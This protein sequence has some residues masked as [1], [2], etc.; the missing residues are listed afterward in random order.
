MKARARFILVLLLLWCL[1][2]LGY[3]KQ[4]SIKKN[5]S[6]G[7][8]YILQAIRIDVPPKIDGFL[9]AE[10]WELAPTATNFIQ[11]Q[12]AEGKPATENTEVRILYDNEN[13]YIGVMCHDS[14]PE[15]IIANEK[16]RDSRNIYDNDHFQIMLDTFHDRRNGYIF[17]INA[18]GAKLDLQV[19]KEGKAEGG[20]HIA[21]PNININWDGVWKVSSA[22]HQKGWSAE[23]EIP[24]VTLRFN[25]RTT[26]GWGVNFL[27]NIRRK[28][29]E[30]SWVPLPRNLNLYKI[31]IAGELKGLEGLKKGLNLQVKTFITV[32]NIGQRG[33]GGK[34]SSVNA[35]DGGVDLKYGLTSNLTLDITV[36]TDFSQVEVDDQQINLTRFSLYFPE[37]RDFFLENA[38]ILSIGSPDD[39]MIFF[40]RRIGI[41]PQREE[42]P[43]LGG[44]KIAGKVNRFNIGFI[45]VQARAKGEIPN[46]NFTVLRVSRD[47]LGK[48]AIGFMMTNRQSKINGDFNRA[49]VIDGDFIFGKNFSLS[50]YFALT[51]S[52]ELKGQNRAAKLGFQWRSDLWDAYGYYFDIQ[53]NFNAEMGFVKRTGIRRAQTHIG[54]TPEP[55]IPGVRRLNPHIF[56]AYTTDQDNNLLLREKHVHMVFD[57]INGGNIGLQWNEDHEYMNYPFSIQ[58]E[59]TVPVGRYTS[60]WWMANF[61]SDRSRKIYTSMSYRWGGFYGGKSRIITLRTGLRPIPS[62]ASEISFVYN[63]I[64]LPQGDFANH[65]LRAKLTYNFSTRLTLMS[66]LQW[67]SDTGEVNVNI[68]LNFIHRPGSDLFI[69]YNE[70]RLVEGLETGILDRTIAVKFTYLFNF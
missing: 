3:E 25:E 12:P 58:E 8:G 42:T 55:D 50:G 39:V 59:I 38:A 56:F 31:S 47:I 26:E 5:K 15:K 20:G 27:R 30:S 28:N 69:V 32:D 61:S 70:R 67:N 46:N 24:L 2:L 33:E 10:I 63:D 16:R 37:K 40:S 19:R 29:E 60:P 53:E 6:K 68:R 7:E 41:S 43:L 9:E 65:L 34:L 1:P 48:S 51:S 52:P 22:I 64:D 18:L 49:F 54:F 66:L 23:I 11:K 36:N 57:L 4:P 21:N 14:E 17:V 62:F 35:I 45:N 13:L 44:V